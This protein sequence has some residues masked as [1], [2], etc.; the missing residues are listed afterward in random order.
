ML[1]NAIN[2]K[3]R[4]YHPSVFTLLAFCLFASSLH[5]QVF[6]LD[7]IKYR[8]DAE[9]RSATVVNVYGKGDIVVPRSVVYNEQELPISGMQPECFMNN[10]DIRTVRLYDNIKEIPPYAF[11]GCSLLSIELPEGLETIKKYAFMSTH[12]LNEVKL[13]QSLEV[14]EE[15][16]FYGSGISSILL[17]DSIQTIEGQAFASSNIV[18]FSFHC[19]DH[20]LNNNVFR[21]CKQLRSMIIEEGTTIVHQ[22]FGG[23]SS[24]ESLYIPASVE[25]LSY[26]A[27]DG[28]NKGGNYLTSV[29]VDPRNKRYDSR[30][31]CNAIIETETNTLLFA[32]PTTVLPREIRSIASYAFSSER[33]TEIPP[34]PNSVEYVHER[35][36]NCLDEIPNLV[37]E[38]GDKDLNLAY[39]FNRNHDDGSFSSIKTLYLGRN[40]TWLGNGK[41]YDENMMK[42]G[43]L[44]LGKEVS[45]LIC[46]VNL[47]TD[48][49]YAQSTN[50]SALDI[51]FKNADAV[52]FLAPLY[53]PIGT[54]EKYRQC[55]GWNKFLNIVEYDAT[56]ISSA[57]TDA[58]K[59]NI[60]NINGHRITGIQKGINIIRDTDGKARKFIRK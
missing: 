28:P 10:K 54:K 52:F 53:V 32:C 16:A 7:G 44:I 39:H 35:A 59:T 4:F 18:E 60:Y 5:A 37:F 20:T 11:C 27:Q 51:D 36:L 57:K 42:V 31:N 19:K 12:N 41:D 6:E 47:Q 23:C 43:T 55:E 26:F 2:M 3:L 25:Q 34:I 33:Q 29:K 9:S 17:P 48:K 38:D 50:P 46:Q 49:V 1:H 13:P 22:N 58:H 40:T 30:D 24:L 8:Y 14:I 45:R 21:F 56:T 15:G